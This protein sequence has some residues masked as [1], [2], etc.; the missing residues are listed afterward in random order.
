M[1][2]LFQNAMI[3]LQNVTVITKCD[4]YYK[5]R[6]YTYLL[7]SFA[8]KQEKFSLRMLLRI[9]VVYLIVD[10]IFII[11]IGPYKIYIKSSKYE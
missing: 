9:D 7:I 3:L 4:V 6:Q 5:L 10:N 11:K 8:Y 2:Q 1:R